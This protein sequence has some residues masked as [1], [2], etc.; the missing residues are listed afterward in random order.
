MFIYYKKNSVGGFEFFPYCPFSERSGLKLIQ[1]HWMSYVAWKCDF[2]AYTFVSVNDVR[3]ML[4][5]R[6][7]KGA[8]K[9]GGIGFTTVFPDEKWPKG[10]KSV[11]VLRGPYLP[12]DFYY[13]FESKMWIAAKRKID[14]S[15]LYFYERD[16]LQ[17]EAQDRIQSQ[18]WQFRSYDSQI[19]EEILEKAGITSNGLVP[20]EIISDEKELWKLKTLEEMHAISASEIFVRKSQKIFRGN[21]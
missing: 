14:S 10:V 17:S 21:I 3:P 15:L 5:C 20:V 2:Y 12:L 1:N 16:E 7:F 19:I 9:T 13:D 11:A 4:D 8:Y 6:H 18:S